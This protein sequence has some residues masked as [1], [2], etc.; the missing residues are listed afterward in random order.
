MPSRHKN[1]PVETGTKRDTPEILIRNVIRLASENGYYG[2]IE[3]ILDYFNPSEKDRK[4]SHYQF[5]FNAVVKPGSNQGTK[6]EV[7]LEGTFD[8][9]GERRLHVAVFKSLSTDIKTFT[10]M[11]AFCGALS[12]YAHKYVNEN[13]ERYYPPE[14]TYE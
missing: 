9:S 6:I 13:I 8:Q 12:Y 2:E 14:N 10:A 11:G 5:D 4:L 7:F 1:V 3:P